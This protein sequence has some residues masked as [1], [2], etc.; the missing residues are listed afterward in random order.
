LGLNRDI[1]PTRRTRLPS[2][3]YAVAEERGEDVREVSEIDVARREAAALE[4]RMAV[5]VV[6]LARLRIREHLVRLG[7]LLE[8][9]GR[10]RRI[11]D[12][13]VQL[14]RELAE[15]PLDVRVASAAFD[16]EQL[17]V[18]ALRRGHRRRVRAEA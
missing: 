3:E 6:E 2:A 1:G 15:G 10:V 16:A 9:I 12:V 18:V 13:R 7:D 8:A 4:S 5:A 14:P 17:V 11:R